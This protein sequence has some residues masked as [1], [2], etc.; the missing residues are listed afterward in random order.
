MAEERQHL[1]ANPLRW[2]LS[3]RLQAVWSGHHHVLRRSGGWHLALRRRDK[4]DA[5]RLGKVADP[6]EEPGGVR[7][8]VELQA[9]EVV[10]MHPFVQQGLKKDLWREHLLADGGQVVDPDGTA[11]RRRF[12]GDPVIAVGL[13]LQLPRAGAMALRAVGHGELAGR[14][15][16]GFIQN[17]E[18]ALASLLPAGR[19]GFVQDGQRDPLAER[20]LTPGDR[21]NALATFVCGSGHASLLWGACRSRASSWWATRSCA[22]SPSTRTPTGWRRAFFNA[23]FRS[24]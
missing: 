3:A 1:V 4:S 15:P 14:Q 10:M 23:A 18:Q 7:R 9:R 20:K 16:G 13:Q 12:P 24:G 21:F 22:A 8:A 19:A 2:R 6:G 17:V 11:L 5:Q